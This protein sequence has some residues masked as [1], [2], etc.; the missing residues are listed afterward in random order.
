MTKAKKNDK[1]DGKTPLEFL[2]MDGVAE[3]CEVFG[4]GAKK[5]GRDNYLL[6]HEQTRLLAAAMRH[7]LL[8][9]AGEDLDPESGST[10]IGHA[11]CCLA[12]LQSQKAVGTSIDDR[13]EEC[14]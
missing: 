12:M 14:K 10:H 13:K 5:Y 7:I 4:F 8:Y 9:Q 2:R 3:M 11:Q 1:V 6:G